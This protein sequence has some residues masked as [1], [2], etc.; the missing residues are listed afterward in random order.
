MSVERTLTQRSR[1]RAR[2]C[3]DSSQGSANDSSSDEGQDADCSD[4][5]LSERRRSPAPWGG[6]GRGL[7][8]LWG[9]PCGR[10]SGLPA[11]HGGPTVPGCQPL[12]ADPQF[13]V[14]SLSRR[15]HSS[16]LPA[17]H[18]GPT[19]P[20]NDPPHKRQKRREDPENTVLTYFEPSSLVQAKEGTFKVPPHMGKYLDCHLKRCLSKEERDALFKEHPKPD[21]ASC[22][23]PKVDRYM[24][25]FLG[26][27]MPR[28]HDNE[29][30]KLQS[31]TLAIVRPLASA[32]SHL[33]DAGLEADPGKVV[34]GTEVLTMLQRT[35][36]LVGN[37]AELI[38]QTRR[39]KILELVDP[40]WSK[41]ATEISLPGSDS[42]FG[43]DFQSTLK[44]RVEKDASLSKAVSI[45]KNSKREKEPTRHEERLPPKPS[46]Q[47][48]PRQTSLKQQIGLYRPHFADSIADL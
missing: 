39:S 5:S 19:V 26:T 25:D 4:V 30:V 32:W 7:T 41:F 15:T 3:P 31:T 33:M 46:Q 24:A 9:G 16:G 27:R 20:P 2:Y 13:R 6:P 35:L 47:V 8:A 28:E 40:S 23:P 10:G 18:G 12:T 14:A 45:T 37:A 48:S 34:P 1:K 17:S 11:S 29:L 21:L 38:S 43:D 42:L 36:C 44:D 22:N